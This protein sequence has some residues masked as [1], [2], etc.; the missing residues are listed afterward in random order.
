MPRTSIPHTLG[1]LSKLAKLVTPE[2]TAGQR[3]MELAH[4]KLQSTLDELNRLLVE[5]DFHAARKQEASQKIRQLLDDGRRTASA[6]RV[7]LKDH[8]GYD[9]EQLVAY[10]VRPS[11]RRK[12]RRSAKSAQASPSSNEPAP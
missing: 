10:D 5:R 7:Y 3:H 1:T 11:R 2:A 12:K 4:E 6:L 8:L 9:N